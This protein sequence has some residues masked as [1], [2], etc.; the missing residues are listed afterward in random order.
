MKK[1]NI[2]FV[3]LL[4]AGLFLSGCSSKEQQAE[5]E[6]NEPEK[7]SIYTTVYPLLYFAEQIGGDLVDAKTIYPPGSDEHT[8]EPSQKDM[9]QLANADL[10]V[11]VGF[12]LEGFVEKAK[13]TLEK[14]NVKLLS[15]GENIEI[16]TDGHETEEEHA[17]E[18]DHGSEEEHAAEDNHSSEEEHAAED[19]HSSEEEHATEDD[20]SS[21][22]DHA[23]ED[24]H[25]HE[26]GD[27]DP[28][29]WLDPLYSLDMAAVIKDKLIELKPEEKETF[30]ANFTALSKELDELHHEFE[31]TIHD[32]KRN[33][34]IVSHA[35]FGYWE[36]RYGIEQ[37]SVAGLSSSDEP[38][39]K[40]LQKVISLAKEESIGYVLFE[41]NVSSKITEIVQKEL[42]A[43]ALNLHNLSVLTEE[44]IKNKEDYITLMRRNLE[45]LKTA[46]N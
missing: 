7:L 37:I 12:G 19:D 2:L 23:V 29:V 41:Q 3:G 18:D 10:F 46:L 38:S 14:E 5:M 21:E 40:E 22:E 17:A 42:G 39:Q 15:A 43:E 34:I 6:K 24:D 36:Q 13:E 32:S 9:I 11:Y 4:I 44:D 45:T 26:H 16:N 8:Y 33:K 27:V 25:G 30:E 28:H 20:H 31:E 1:L 35:A